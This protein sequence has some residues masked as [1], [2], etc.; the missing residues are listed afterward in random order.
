[1]LAFRRAYSVGFTKAILRTMA[2]VGTYMLVVGLTLL[3]ITLPVA[4]RG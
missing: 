2:V 1:V 3:A 4:F